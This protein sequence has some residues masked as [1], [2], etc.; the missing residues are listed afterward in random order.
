[1]NNVT[2]VCSTCHDGAGIGTI[3]HFNNVLN[4]SVLA[5]YNAKS[6]TASYTPGAN[7]GTCTN[8]SC[9]GGQTTPPWR[10]KGG[11]NVNT[12]CTSCH[13][14]RAVSDQFNSYFSGNPVIGPPAFPN[15]HDRHVVGIG[16]VCTDC[17]DTTI[18]AASHFVGL[19]TSAFEGVPAVTIRAAVTY[20]GSVAS[21]A[22]S[23]SPVN[24][25]TNFTI[26]IC[27]PGTRPWTGP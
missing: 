15:L 4:S 24:T 10:P 7:G 11:I 8:V 22:S 21:G 6:G 3:N 20:T 2:G 19:N 27:H 23:C 13:R 12:Q 26:G 9:H 17:H 1:L 16:L 5:A 18:L 25:G 14:S